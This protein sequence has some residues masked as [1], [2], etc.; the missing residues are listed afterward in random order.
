MTDF[1]RCV[2]QETARRME[3]EADRITLAHQQAGA[4]DIDTWKLQEKLRDSLLIQAGQVR[5]EL[6]AGVSTPEK[7]EEKKP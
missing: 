3:A 2:L 4:W 6:D 5:R 7:P 1:E